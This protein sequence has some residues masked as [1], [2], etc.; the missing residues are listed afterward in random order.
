[1]VAMP[2]EDS[3]GLSREIARLFGYDLMRYKKSFRFEATLDRLLK[4]HDFNCVLDIGANNGW[5]SGHCIK[6]LGSV[7]VYSFEPANT[8][9]QGLR[10]K[11]AGRPHWK[12]VQ[13]ALGDQAGE[14]MLNLSGGSGV[15]N[16]LNA[17]NPEFVDR[18]SE[19]NFVGSETVTVTTLDAFARENA[20]ADHDGLLIKIDTQGHDFKV[21]K[22][23]KE[24]LASARAVII[25]LPFQ[26]IYDTTE[27]YR[28][29]LD[30]MD[31]AGF[32]I[33]SLS[34][35]SPGQDGALIEADGFFIRRNK[36]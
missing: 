18:F 12:I 4:N 25:E 5:F 21:L 10:E 36:T 7:P 3:M 14:A 23:G 13:A 30:F 19:L 8:L 34:P 2:R 32:D 20:L 29:I 31:E 22:G 26:N 17:A 9:A 16:S 11:A 24:T 28:D 6:K 35:I 33:Y 1:M 15:F 27:S